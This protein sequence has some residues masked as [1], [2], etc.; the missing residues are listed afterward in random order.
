MNG[1]V[2][3]TPR[4]SNETVNVV[5]L[6]PDPSGKGLVRVEWWRFFPDS[7]GLRMT[8]ATISGIVRA[9]YIHSF[10]VSRPAVAP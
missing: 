6:S 8:N 3:C 1:N 7:S 4:H 5:T 10:S 9:P 2:K